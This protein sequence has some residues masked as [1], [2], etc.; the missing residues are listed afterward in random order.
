MSRYFSGVRGRV[1]FTVLAV[2]AGLYSILGT[3]G[4][5]AI[6][7]GGRADIRERVNV[8]VD[9]L[10]SGLANGEAAVSI[11]TADG[12]EARVV[13]QAEPVPPS[14]GS[15]VRLV[16]RVMIADRSLELF[17]R[18]SDARLSASLQ[19]L[20]RVLWLGI[21]MAAVLTAAMAGAATGRALRPI[22]DLTT[23]AGSVGP[24]DDTTRV[25]VPDTGDEI[26]HLALTINEML[27][28]IGA[29]LQAHR[30]F[31]SDAAHELRTPLMALQGEIELAQT[32]STSTDPALLDRLAALTIRLGT[33]VD[34]LL[35]LSALDEAPPL[36]RQPA[37]LLDILRAESAAL[38]DPIEVTGDDS[39]A[40][41]DHALIGR[42]VR[43]LLTNA[44]R[45]AH[46]VVLASVAHE[47]DLVWLRVDD[48]GPGIDPTDRIEV[49]Q[50]F[51]R[52]DEARNADGGGAG[53]G[54]SITASIAHAHGGGVS[55]ETSPAGG[56]RFSLWLPANA[57]R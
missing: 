50:R 42:A 9:R 27:D 40:D 53:L 52:L 5:L 33:R 34:E 49:F 23:L 48:D 24:G 10:E 14:V 12:V 47:G 6:A 16:R 26:E 8:V 17:G 46:E 31:T 37:R 20:H 36:L 18:A 32:T 11:S 4:F 3:V 15:E 38:A 44:Q 13:T 39:T 1:V 2:T 19:S 35:L 21:A 25:P 41:V 57:D 56:A 29:G 30:R 7:N 43:N 54:L 51:R 28:R 22:A 55:V 45:H